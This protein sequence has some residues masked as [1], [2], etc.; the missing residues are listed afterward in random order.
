MLALLRTRVIAL[1]MFAFAAFPLCAFAQQGFVI[2]PK[3]QLVLPNLAPAGN[4]PT[5][6]GCT[7]AAGST[8][9]AGNCAATAASGS[10]A[11]AATY[12]NPPNCVVIDASATAAGSGVYTVTAAQIT[13][14]TI[15]STHVYRWSCLPV[16]GY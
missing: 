11:F 15:T 16:A 9:M 3:S 5:G 7:I 6:T 2:P 12:T 13:L 10:I 4:P 1:S 8:D 14:T